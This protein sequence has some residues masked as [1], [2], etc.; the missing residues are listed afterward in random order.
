MS[1]FDL[2][3]SSIR[4]ALIE[5]EF[6][7]LNDMQQKAVFKT[8]GPLLL[9]AGAG[10]GKTTVLINRII[11]LLRFGKA[12][13]SHY[14]PDWAGDAELTKLAH[15]LND[16]DSLDDPEIQR[17]CAVDPPR[18]YEIIAITFTN[19][20]AGELKERLSAACG[21]AAND[22]EGMIAGIGAYNIESLSGLNNIKK[23]KGSK[24]G[25]KKD[26]DLKDNL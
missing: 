18:P 9:L 20:A 1:D 25:S 19:K 22:I 14:A 26:P 2:R 16:D 15:A 7:R 24:D 12:Y 23:G 10:S 4:R 11:N 5:R 3:Y 21:A 8:E 13:E 17:L 6:S